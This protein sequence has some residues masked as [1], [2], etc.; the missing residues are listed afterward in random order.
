MRPA[1]IICLRNR[2]SFLPIVLDTEVKFLSKF[3]EGTI[4]SHFSAAFGDIENKCYF[5][6]ILFFKE[7]ELQ[8]FQHFGRKVLE[9][10][11]QFV[12]QGFVPILIVVFDQFTNLVFF[13]AEYPFSPDPPVMLVYFVTRDT[14]KPRGNGNSP[15]LK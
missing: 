4:C 1:V 10:F 13:D 7:A 5:P 14:V 6:E 3:V 9:V 11:Q 2:I 12:Y 15:V 8:D